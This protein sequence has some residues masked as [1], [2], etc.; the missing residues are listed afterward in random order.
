M[1]ARMTEI[2]TPRRKRVFSPT[3]TWP[4]VVEGAQLCSVSMAAHP[5]VETGRHIL[6]SDGVG[7]GRMGIVPPMP[8]RTRL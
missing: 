2:A 4:G 6:G 1:V 3:E 5:L 8:V 7:W